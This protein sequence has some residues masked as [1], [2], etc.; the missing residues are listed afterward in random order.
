LK[1]SEEDIYSAVEPH[2]PMIYSDS[3]GISNTVNLVGY[4]ITLRNEVTKMIH[5]TGWK[6]TFTFLN[7]LELIGVEDCFSRKSK[8]NSS[9]KIIFDSSCVEM[10]NSKT[11]TTIQTQ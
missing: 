1:P 3:D 9:E 7:I 2:I 5:C 8:V 4:S 10:L 11:F 6:D